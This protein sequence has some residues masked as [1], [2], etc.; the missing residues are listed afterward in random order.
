MLPYSR[1]DTL[2]VF[3]VR[4]LCEVSKD[5]LV[6]WVGVEVVEQV[7][8]VLFGWTAIA[9]R[10][11]V[12]VG[13]WVVECVCVYVGVECVGVCVC[14]GGGGVCGV[15]CVC[16]CVCVGGGAVYGVECVW[17]G[18]VEC[19]YGVC[20]CVCGCVCGGGVIMTVSNTKCEAHIIL[21]NPV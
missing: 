6:L 4:G 1:E 10:T 9:L 12:G 7:F 2:N 15:E 5:S 11:C 8:N 18:M 17:G 19:V 3:S 20:G 16:V 13:V 14:M 21:W